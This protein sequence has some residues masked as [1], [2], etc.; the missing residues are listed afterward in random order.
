MTQGEQLKAL[1]QRKKTNLTQL[2]KKSGVPRETLSRIA[3]DKQS[4]GADVAGKIA[5]ALGVRTTELVLPRAAEVE[6]RGGLDRRLQSVER[7]ADWAE[8]TLI[9]VLEGML[10]ADLAR[11]KPLAARLSAAIAARP[12]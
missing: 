3:N 4:L 12:R 9:L 6:S 10:E 11:P 1:V 7:R 5:S 2:A 8:E